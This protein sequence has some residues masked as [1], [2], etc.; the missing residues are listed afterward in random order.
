MSI[1]TIVNIHQDIR[2][3]DDYIVSFFSDADAIGLANLYTVNG[4]L[5]PP[6]KELIQG[7]ENI[8]EYWQGIMN[9]GYLM[10]NLEILEVEQHYDTAIE[11]GKYVMMGEGSKVLDQGKYVVVWKLEYEQWKIHRK[12]FNSN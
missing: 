9:L 3:L 11:T 6:G 12:I 4:M 10:V 8:L 7:R 5:L 2:E 1:Q